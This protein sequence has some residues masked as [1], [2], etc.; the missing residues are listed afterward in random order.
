MYIGPWQELRLAQNIL[1]NNKK[2]DAHESSKSEIHFHKRKK[3]LNKP[4][5]PPIKH[6]NFIG[7][8]TKLSANNALLS[9]SIIKENNEEIKDLYDRLKSNPNNSDSL[10]SPY[11]QGKAKL[12]PQSKC[13]NE[14]NKNGYKFKKGKK[15][16]KQTNNNVNNNSMRANDTNKE[17][18]CIN[19]NRNYNRRPSS[20]AKNNNKPK[21]SKN[22]RQINKMRKMYLKN[23]SS[24]LDEKIENSGSDNDDKIK[25]KSTREELATPKICSDYDHIACYFDSPTR[26]SKNVNNNSI[27][28]AFSLPSISR[29]PQHEH[30]MSNNS[31]IISTSDDEKDLLAWIDGL[32]CSSFL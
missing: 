18:N 8:K 27:E 29:I 1:L 3:N 13:E 4:P 25:S 10:S 6:D 28:S 22:I 16:K 12:S 31:S 9:S 24:S 21:I 20:L 19:G 30:V 7:L 5:L 11:M 32:D 2:H 17:N 26:I 15:K 23:A 14:S